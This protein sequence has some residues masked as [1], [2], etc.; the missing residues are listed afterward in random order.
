M[1]D[2]ELHADEKDALRLLAQVGATPVGMIDWV[3]Q[4]TAKETVELIRLARQSAPQGEPMTIKTIVACLEV[5]AGNTDTSPK[6]RAATELR[7]I[8]GWETAT[9]PIAYPP[10]APDVVRDALLAINRCARQ[11]INRD[12]ATNAHDIIQHLRGAL[13][14]ITEISCDATIDAAMQSAGAKDE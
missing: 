4:I 12:D 1:T 6:W 8:V 11:A 7:R 9:L 14:T 5:S 3:F 13:A 10:A 2:H